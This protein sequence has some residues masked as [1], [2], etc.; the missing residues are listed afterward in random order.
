MERDFLYKNNTIVWLVLLA[1]R[2]WLAGSARMNR[3]D[4]LYTPPEGSGTLV[5]PLWL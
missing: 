1:Y 4:G 3:A 2:R 5:F